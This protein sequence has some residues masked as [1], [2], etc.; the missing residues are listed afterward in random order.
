MKNKQTRKK[1][2]KKEKRREGEGEGEGRKERRREAS[3][4]S[5][6]VESGRAEGRRGT[7][8]GGALSEI[9][10]DTLITKRIYYLERPDKYYAAAVNT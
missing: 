7:R 8:G 9:I 5:A 4:N 2:K 1:R 6:L 3:R 10:L